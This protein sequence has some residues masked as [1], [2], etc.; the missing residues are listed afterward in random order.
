MI[1]RDCKAALAPETGRPAP[2]QT[3]LSCALMRLFTRADAVSVFMV[4]LLIMES[5]VEAAVLDKGRFLY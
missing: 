4:L 2:L 5:G 3:C 1:M